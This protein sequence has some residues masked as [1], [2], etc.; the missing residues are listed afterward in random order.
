MRPKIGKKTTR[1]RKPISAGERLA[2]TLRFFATGETYRSTQYQNRL[3]PS[4]ISSIVTEVCGAIIEALAGEY[5]RF[6]SNEEDWHK[7]AKE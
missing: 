7:V 6:P 4:S 5:I 1:L 3:S 2:V